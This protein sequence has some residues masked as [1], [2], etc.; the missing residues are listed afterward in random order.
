MLNYFYLWCWKIRLQCLLLN[1]FKNTFASKMQL[2]NIKSYNIT[3]K[4]FI[5]PFYGKIKKKT[6]SSELKLLF[7]YVSVL[8]SAEVLYE[9]PF[10]EKNHSTH[11]NNEAQPL[12]LMV[13][14]CTATSAV[15]QDVCSLS[16]AF[17]CHFPHTD[18]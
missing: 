15:Q 18:A 9:N 10:V 3:V 13:L 2:R 17:R 11:L 16:T 4:E 12:F 14:L 7:S 6:V 5:L 1:P 8:K